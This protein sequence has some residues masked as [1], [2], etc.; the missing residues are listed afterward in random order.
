MKKMIF[1]LLLFSVTKL[2]GSQEDERFEG[3][4]MSPEVQ[5]Q[6]NE[7]RIRVLKAFLSKNNLEGSVKKRLHEFL[8][9]ELLHSGGFAFHIPKNAS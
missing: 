4:P 8:Q 9:E 3:E 2:Y 5:R 7:G 6:R 1:I